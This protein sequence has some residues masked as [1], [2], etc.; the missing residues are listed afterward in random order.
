[1]GSNLVTF[2]ST[3]LGTPRLNGQNKMMAMMLMR[4][5]MARWMA[6]GW[7]TI[8]CMAIALAAIAA[9]R[10]VAPGTHELRNTGQLLGSELIFRHLL[11]N[12]YTL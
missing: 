10:L 3:P 8:K 4:W 2:E 5:M 12:D 11:T 6:K 9:T 7:M 1:M